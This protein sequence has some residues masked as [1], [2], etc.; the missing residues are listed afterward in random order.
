MFKSALTAAIALAGIVQIAIALS[1]LAIP[2]VL[3]WSEQT[4]QL[5]PLTRQVF[6]TYAGYVFATNL[7]FGV[8]SA[9]APG[10]LLERTSLGAAVTAFISV[11]WAV[12]V[13]LQFTVYDRAVV[14]RPLFAVAEAL[15]VCAFAALAL[16]YAVAAAFNLGVVSR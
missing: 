9:G 5:V 6:W 2:R 7:A 14:T 1:S 3:R 13:T 4:A 12:R 15:Y 8:L 16:V 11:Y 10:A